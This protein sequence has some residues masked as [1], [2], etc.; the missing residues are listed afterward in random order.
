MPP[1]QPRIVQLRVLRVCVCICV[2]C[3]VENEMEEVPYEPPELPPLPPPLSEDPH[4]PSHAARKRKPKQ[5][6]E[7]PTDFFELKVNTNVYI[8]GLPEDATVEELEKHFSKCGIIRRD[9]QTGT[10][11]IRAIG[12][13]VCNPL[14]AEE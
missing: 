14:G 13:G 7:Q 1:M 8:Q 9:P 5:Q 11:G 4:P 2:V 6:P 10:I 3:L 12:S